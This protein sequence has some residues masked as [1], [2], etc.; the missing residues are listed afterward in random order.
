MLGNK[1]MK[2]MFVSSLSIAAVALGLG[3]CAQPEIPQDKY[4][5]LNVTTSAKAAVKLDGVLEVER[6][7]ADG[8]ISGRPIAYSE[9]KGHL[10]EYHYHFWVE[11]PVDLLQDA[12]VS[13][14]RN[15]RMYAL[16]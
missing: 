6:F 13:F 2:K 10:S 5:R 7:R 9:N 1:I 12:M 11:P 8:L 4:Y 3:A 14:L 16:L 15:A